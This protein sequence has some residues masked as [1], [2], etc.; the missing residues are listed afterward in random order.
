M[1]GLG[2]NLFWH[3]LENLQEGF[4][5]KASASSWCP[6]QFVQCNSK[7]GLIVNT[8]LLTSEELNEIEMLG[9]DGLKYVHGSANKHWSDR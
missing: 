2:H 6:I 8:Q 4:V 1:E 7:N 9:G 3:W 5:E